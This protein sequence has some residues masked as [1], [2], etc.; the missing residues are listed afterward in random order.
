MTPRAFPLGAPRL[1]AKRRIRCPQAHDAMSRHLFTFA[2]GWTQTTVYTNHDGRLPEAVIQF[3]DRDGVEVVTAT[4]L[5]VGT[6]TL[7]WITLSTGD[8]STDK[9]GSGADGWW[10]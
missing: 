2:P 10:Q 8:A 3:N 7:G 6:D 5:L 1:V 9:A 4:P